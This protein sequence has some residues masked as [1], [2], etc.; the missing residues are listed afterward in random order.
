MR[1]PNAPIT[2]TTSGLCTVEGYTPRNYHGAHLDA[3]TAAV[4]EIRDGGASGQILDTLRVGAA[5]EDSTPTYENGVAT[6]GGIYVN[7]VSGTVTVTVY[8]S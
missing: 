7:V 4:V 2:R 1:G 8:A 5:G 3:T 6:A